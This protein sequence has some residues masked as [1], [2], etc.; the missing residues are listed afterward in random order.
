M[1]RRPN[2]GFVH[3]YMSIHIWMDQ[4]EHFRKFGTITLENY[5]RLNCAYG[6]TVYALDKTCKL[7][8]IKGLTKV[9]G[10]GQCEKLDE[11][12]KCSTLMIVLIDMIYGSFSHLFSR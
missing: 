2:W 3:D 7:D 11:D 10:F 8:T 12:T 1:S 9:A 6:A 4:S 5:F